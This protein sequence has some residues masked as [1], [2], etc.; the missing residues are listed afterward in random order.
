MHAFLSHLRI[1][2]S[3]G[4]GFLLSASLLVVPIALADSLHVFSS[5][6]VVSSARLNANFEKMVP[7]GTI[8]AWNKT[9]SGTP[10]I[11]DGWLECN[12]QPVSDTESPYHGQSVPNLNNPPADPAGG[13]TGTYSKGVFLRGDN[14]SGTFQ[15]DSI[16]GHW[17]SQN[18]VVTSIPGDG[19]HAHLNSTA[20][21]H[22]NSLVRDPSSDGS[23][24]AP[25]TAAETRPVNYSVVW[26]MRIK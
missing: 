19:T 23:N 10:G 11:P 5:G 21:G 4:L 3:V 14:T 1:G 26:I 24:G 20:W 2:M 12:G 13:A 25:R 17:H 16:Q 8:V 7:V 15:D 6:E 18:Q 9:M 22:N